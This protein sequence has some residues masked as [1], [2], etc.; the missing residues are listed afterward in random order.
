MG[1]RQGRLPNLRIHSASQWLIIQGRLVGKALAPSAPVTVV[2]RL[3]PAQQPHPAGWRPEAGLPSS[4]DV[5]GACDA[6]SLVSNACRALPLRQASRGAAP[7]IRADAAPQSGQGQ[8]SLR[9]AR[10]RNASKAPQ[11]GHA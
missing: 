7:R 8:G 5:L 6:R 10:L 3:P 9:C 2:L 4:F 11:S 1:D